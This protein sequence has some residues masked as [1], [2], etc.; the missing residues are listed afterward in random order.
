M[1]KVTRVEGHP[2]PRQ[3]LG[4]EGAGQRRSADDIAADRDE[5]SLQRRRRLIRVAIGGNQ[6]VARSEIASR[7]NNGPTGRGPRHAGHR[8]ALKDGR[9]S[10][11]RGA[12]QP[13]H[14]FR[15]VDRGALFVNEQPVI[16]ASAKLGRLITSFDDGHLVIEHS[17]EQ[18]LL[19]AKGG[20]VTGL[21]GRL[22]VSG[23]SRS[24]AIG[25]S[26]TTCSSAAIASRETSNS[27]RARASPYVET[28]VPTSSLSPVNTW[29]ALRELAPDPTCPRSRTA[30][31]A[32][33]RASWRA[34][35]R[36]V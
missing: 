20:K 17:S 14:V 27:S 34:A 10:P 28:R 25:S 36:P 5:P 4:G 23:S 19:F 2:P 29:P 18:R 33:A 6:H 13:V 12:R 21:G 3:K 24:Q 16:T 31:D 22:K 8:S 7:C 9:T 30:T 1:Q 26:A 11:R 15:R 32:P 35:E